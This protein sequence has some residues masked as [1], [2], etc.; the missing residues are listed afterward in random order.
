MILN[1]IENDFGPGDTYTINTNKVF[2]VKTDF[3]EE[4]EQF[5][6]YTTT[7]T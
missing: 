2:N 5:V 4:L 3:H 1:D 7:M 6:G